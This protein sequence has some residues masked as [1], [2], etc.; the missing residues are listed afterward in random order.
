MLCLAR[1]EPEKGEVHDEKQGKE[2]DEVLAFAFG[3]GAEPVDE[4]LQPGEDTAGR[5]DRDNAGI[6]K[7]HHALCSLGR[8][9]ALDILS[10]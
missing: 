1:Q 5:D 2:E 9:Q 3:S 6:E 10:L 7:F 4:G 8:R